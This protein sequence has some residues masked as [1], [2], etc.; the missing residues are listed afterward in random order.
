MKAIDEVKVL[1]KGYVR[2]VDNMGSDLSIVRA[3]RVSYDKDDFDNDEIIFTNKDKKLIDYLWKNKHTSPFESC[4]ITLE[5]K[6]PIFI[7]RQWHRH[8]TQSYNEVSA[9]YTELPDEF[10][11]PS[12][13][14]IGKQ[15]TS[16]KQVRILSEEEDF[17]DRSH[18]QIALSD[19][20]DFCKTAFDRY[21]RLLK[22]GWPRE[23]AR[24]VLPLST[25]SRMYSTANLLNWFR[26]LTLRTHE[27][28]QWEIQQYANA[29]LQLIEQV[30]PVAT[31][32]WRT[33]K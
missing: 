26:F 16:N 27:H 30:V 11:V 6:A 28:A 4:T 29:I 10:Y 8:R 15:S 1:D 14:T 7:F 12:I 23:L 31:Q 21:H 24:M 22:V 18:Q 9:R 2:L 17:I 5:V 20:E 19:Y 3:A 13:E 25:Y 32:A 33:Y